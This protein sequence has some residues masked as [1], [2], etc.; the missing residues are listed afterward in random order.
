MASFGDN[1][2]MWICFNDGFVSVV[3]DRNNPA[4]LLVRARR[5][6]DLLNVCGKDVEVLKDAGTD[7][8]WRTF[9]DRKAFSA[10][11]AARIDNIGYT[12]FK[13]SVK[14]HDL[15]DMYMDF[16]SRHYRYQDQYKE[17][18]NRS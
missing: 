15:H 5:K 12:N 17:Q 13:N 11:V 1:G 7:Y 2:S 16:W 8:R 14:D 9:V 3:A 18:G 6:Q 10:L 4:R